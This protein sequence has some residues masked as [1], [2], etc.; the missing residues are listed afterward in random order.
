MTTR[1][2]KA[3]TGTRIILGAA[4]LVALAARALAD[5]A[6][7]LRPVRIRKAKIRKQ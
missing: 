5:A 1:A 7:I 4:V 2:S 3:S 6:G